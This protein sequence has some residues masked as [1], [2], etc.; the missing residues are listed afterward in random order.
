[1]TESDRT[2]NTIINDTHIRTNNNGFVATR[3]NRTLFIL[4]KS[5]EQTKQAQQLLASTSFDQLFKSARKGPRAMGSNT[6]FI[7]L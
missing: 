7:K 4:G 1:M 3:G 5:V 6:R 2:M